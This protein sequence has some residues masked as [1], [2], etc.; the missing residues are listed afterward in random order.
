MRGVVKWF[1]EQRGYGFIEPDGAG[2]DVFVHYSEILDKGFKT[3][4]EGQRVEFS[5]EKGSKGPKAVGVHKLEG[6]PDKKT[7]SDQ[8]GDKK[9]LLDAAEALEEPFNVPAG[10]RLQLAGSLKEM[11]RGLR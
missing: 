10:K 9:T 11:S 6:K 5:V 4:E 3:L 1:D 2:D 8:P 7:R